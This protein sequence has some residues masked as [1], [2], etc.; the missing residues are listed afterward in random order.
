MLNHF[1]P[2]EGA[3]G[4]QFTPL[5]GTDNGAMVDDAIGIGDG[6]TTYNESSIPGHVDHLSF[7]D[8]PYSAVSGVLKAVAFK[9]LV[10]A[11]DGGAHT[12]RN[13][14]KKGGTTVNGTTRSLGTPYTYHV[15]GFAKDPETA[16]AWSG[17]AAAVAAEY[18]YELVS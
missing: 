3:S 8:T 2:T 6:D 17:I 13:G 4:Q 15:D 10:K 11:P 1:T 7:N 16:A 18:K 9:T 5:S 12:W 14:V